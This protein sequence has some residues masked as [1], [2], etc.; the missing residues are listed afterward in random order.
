L[1]QTVQDLAQSVFSLTG[2][3]GRVQLAADGEEH[4]MLG[5]DAPDIHDVFTFPVEHGQ[6]IG[7]EGKEL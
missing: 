4:L 2:A 1:D 6:L 7:G 3:H 5:I